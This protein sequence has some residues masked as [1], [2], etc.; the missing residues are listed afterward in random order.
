MVASA[1]SKSNGF[2]KDH[3]KKAH[4]QLKPLRSLG[5]K[6]RS[7]LPASV[8]AARAAELATWSPRHGAFVPFVPL[9]R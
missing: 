1:K 4:A 5:Q 6:A 3:A 2:Q 7:G 9:K 8:P